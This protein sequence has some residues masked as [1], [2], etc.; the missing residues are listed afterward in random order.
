MATRFDL[1]HQSTNLL[2]VPTRN[3]N[4]AGSDSQVSYLM[5]SLCFSF[6]LFVYHRLV[7]ATDEVSKNM[8][9]LLGDKLAI[10]LKECL[11]LYLRIFFCNCA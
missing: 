5:C 4:V 1:G 7:I 3:S 10:F 11:L 2:G 9:N 6:A 8:A